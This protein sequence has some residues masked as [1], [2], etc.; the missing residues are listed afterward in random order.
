MNNQPQPPNKKKRF[1]GRRKGGP[2]KINKSGPETGATSGP[3]QPRSAGSNNT[4]RPQGS[5]QHRQGQGQGQERNPQNQNHSK[6]TKRQ[7]LEL[8]REQYYAK[9]KTY[10][11]KFA[12]LEARQ[13]LNYENDI[14][15]ITEKMRKIEDFLEQEKSEFPS[16][17]KGLYPEERRYEKE[18][19]RERGQIQEV[20][21]QEPSNVH[22]NDLQKS[23]P[24]YNDDKEESVGSMDDYLR[25][26]QQKPQKQ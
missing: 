16:K 20:V 8:L 19:A 9:R 18:F 3:G 25:I 4:H 24:K 22:I 21:V 10:Y 7:Q 15:N 14:A 12:K 23:R 11:E 6:L 2:Q 13:R 5:G 26:K 1:F 17:E